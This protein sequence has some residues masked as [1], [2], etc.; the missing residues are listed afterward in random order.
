MRK[1]AGCCPRPRSRNKEAEQTPSRVPAS[2]IG[3]TG[4]LDLVRTEGLD[5][6]LWVPL[7]HE[8][9]QKLPRNTFL[10]SITKFA[11]TAK[12]CPL[13]SALFQCHPEQRQFS[14][15]AQSLLPLSLLPSPQGPFRE[16]GRRSLGRG[17]FAPAC[18]TAF[19]SW[20]G[21]GRTK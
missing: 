7:G 15:K 21:P 20:P 18:S 8:Q 2:I 1:A 17:S 4:I 11:N 5:P 14:T 10:P 6:D 13:T 9:S 12:A 19:G 16:C 3:S